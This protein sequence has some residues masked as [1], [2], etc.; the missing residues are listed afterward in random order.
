MFAQCPKHGTLLISLVNR[1]GRETARNLGFKLCA[2]PT[3]LAH[4]FNERFGQP[5]L[6]SP[7]EF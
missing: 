1:N 7:L 2:V 6:G 3:S 4:L 5:D